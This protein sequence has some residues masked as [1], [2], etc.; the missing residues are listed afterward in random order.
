[1]GPGLTDSLLMPL[2][3]TGMFAFLSG[4]W[5]FAVGGGTR[6][7]RRVWF[8]SVIFM[9]L[10]CEA[11]AWHKEIAQV[12][13]FENAWKFLIVIFFV[14]SVTFYFYLRKR[15]PRSEIVTNS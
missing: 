7:I 14:A 8:S 4:G 1:M 9:F 15:A 12:T 3:F 13:G 6:R 5:T 2:L 10:S 11:M